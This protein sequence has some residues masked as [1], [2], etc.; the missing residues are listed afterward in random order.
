MT[1]PNPEPPK[2]AYVRLNGIE[3]AR[4]EFIRKLLLKTNGRAT[5]SDAIRYAITATF[6]NES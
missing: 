4:L 2:T 6:E 5:D 3:R 1:K